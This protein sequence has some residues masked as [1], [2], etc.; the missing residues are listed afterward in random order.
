MIEIVITRL[1]ARVLLVSAMV[2]LSIAS[3]DAQDTTALAKTTQN[4]VGDILS[5][6]FEFNFNGGGGLVDQTQLNLNFQPVLP[7]KATPAL[8]L[9]LRIIVPMQS[10]PGPTDVKTGGVGDIQEQLLF[11]P[12]KPGKLIWGAGPTFSLPTATAYPAQTGTWAGGLSVV[13]LTMPGRWVIGGLITQLWPMSDAGGPPKTNVLACKCFINYNF[14]KGWALS[15]VPVI[16]ANWDAPGGQQW[17]VPVVAASRASSCSK[18]RRCRLDFSTSRTSRGPTMGRRHKCVS[19]SRS[20]IQRSRKR[21]LCA[22]RREV[23]KS[24]S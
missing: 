21:R 3:A 11:T 23:P 7:I 24:K 15:S 17:N 4:P 1:G 5:V 14:G 19:I 6:P 8:N 10:F 18:A 13:A 2:P 22:T 20:S 16:T 12:A 9:I